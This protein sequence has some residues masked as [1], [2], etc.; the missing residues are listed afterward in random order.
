MS[1]R[2]CPCVDIG[3]KTDLELNCP[4]KRKTRTILQ[5][6]M[7]LQKNDVRD[8]FGY[9]D[10]THVKIARHKYQVEE[11]KVLA[12]FSTH[13]LSCSALNI[14]YVKFNIRNAVHQERRPPP[15]TAGFTSSSRQTPYSTTGQI[16]I[17]F[18]YDGVS[19]SACYLVENNVKSCLKE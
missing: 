9:R 4:F 10:A 11:C 15:P 8:E 17:E 16:S 7:E 14:L 13:C 5:E 6:F 18:I 3:R 1:L 2:I 12:Y 19:L